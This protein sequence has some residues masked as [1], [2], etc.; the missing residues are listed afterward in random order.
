MKR[1]QL[2]EKVERAWTDFQE[3]YAGL[4]EEQ[5]L[6]PGVSGDWSV[7]DSIAHVTWW[8]QEALKY[9]PLILKGERPP[10]YADLY[11]GIN[12]FNA[13]MA[14]QRRG[15]SLSEV[16]H[17]QAENHARLIELIQSVPE[18]QFTTE[19]RFRRRLRLDT[20]SHYPEH[21]RQIHA[22]RERTQSNS[23]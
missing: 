19:T 10:L 17:Q 6:E 14:E 8:E 23:R 20:Y 11:G 22:W 16:R 3:S 5:M 4:S 13:L 2:L 15:L 9:L 21:T 12:A 7:K 1:Q 18:D